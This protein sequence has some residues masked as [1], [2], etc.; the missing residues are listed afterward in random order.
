[1]PIEL[2]SSLL[3]YV[4]IWFS[5]IIVPFK[6]FNAL[7]GVIPLYIDIFLMNFYEQD[8]RAKLLTGASILS[9]VGI[10]WARRLY[11]ANIPIA[12]QIQWM[13]VFIFLGYGIFSIIIVLM[14]KMNLINAL[15]KRKL[16][17]FFG[18]SFYPLQV[19][20]IPYSNEAL[21]SVLVMLIPVWLA[22]EL[23]FL[24]KNPIEL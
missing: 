10:D 20:A 8:T 19:G 14:K 15:G 1:M 2:L 3:N 23:V 13:L 7:W 11:Q 6:D 24:K 9:F 22:L 5:L 16:V 17:T 4:Q 21:I 12:F 18:I